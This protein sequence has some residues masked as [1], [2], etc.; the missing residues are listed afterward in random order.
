MATAKT[1]ITRPPTSTRM[2]LSCAVISADT[3]T[4]VNANPANIAAIYKPTSLSHITIPPST[5]FY[6]EGGISVFCI[7]SRKLPLIALE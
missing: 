3:G 6:A 2:P 1:M 4:T 5:I 7:T